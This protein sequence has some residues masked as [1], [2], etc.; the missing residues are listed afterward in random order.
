MRYLNCDLRGILYHILYAGTAK[1]EV[2]PTH[3]PEGDHDTSYV[4]TFTL[5]HIAHPF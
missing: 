4:Q 2:H 3:R 1:F 5:I